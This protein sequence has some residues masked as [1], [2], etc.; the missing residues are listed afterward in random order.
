LS[1][2]VSLSFSYCIYISPTKF[3]RKI[4]RVRLQKAREQLPTTKIPRDPRVILLLWNLSSRG[5]R[6][7]FSVLPVLRP[8]QF[9]GSYLRDFLRVFERF[10]SLAGK[11]I[12]SGGLGEGRWCICLLSRVYC[13]DRRQGVIVQFGQP[14]DVKEDDSHSR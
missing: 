7:L 12:G 5:T 3:R 2:P 13:M 10:L 4:A 1:L 6:T 9:S 11:V 14:D 8:L